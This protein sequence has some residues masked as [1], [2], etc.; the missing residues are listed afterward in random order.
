M[1]IVGVA[2]SLWLP[3][4]PPGPQGYPVPQH[5][6]ICLLPP[7]G[8]DTGHRACQGCSVPQRCCAMPS[9]ACLCSPS[10]AA[11]P[12]SCPQ[13]SGCSTMHPASLQGLHGGTRG[14]RGESALPPGVGRIPGAPPHTFLMGSVVP[15]HAP[16]TPVASCQV[17]PAPHL[18]VVQRPEEEFAVLHSA[19][20]AC[21]ACELGATRAGSVLGGRAPKGTLPSPLSHRVCPAVIFPPQGTKSGG[22][23]CCAQCL[24]P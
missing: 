9:S 21:D 13:L 14:M 19:C 23:P 18:E 11:A 8:L 16:L 24:A 20:M 15:A 17:P 1:G 3:A 2:D 6:P 4:S 12:P 10:T 22:C 5:T 7:W